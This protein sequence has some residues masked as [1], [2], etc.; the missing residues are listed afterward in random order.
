MNLEKII[1]EAVKEVLGRERK[2]ATLPKG[3]ICPG[4]GKSLEDTCIARMVSESPY[5]NMDPDSSIITIDV[6]T[7]RVDPIGEVTLIHDCG[8]EMPLDEEDYELDA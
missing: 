1:K 2:T 8:F 3:L 5:V 6:N 4:C 7:Y